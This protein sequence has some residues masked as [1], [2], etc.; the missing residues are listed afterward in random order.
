MTHDEN[1]GVGDR[2]RLG[3]WASAEPVDLSKPFQADTNTICLFH[4]DDV[5]GGEVKDVVPGGKSGKVQEPS[6]AEGK[7]AGALNCEADKGWADVTDLAKTE[8]IEALTVEC[9]VKFRGL[10]AGDVICRGDHT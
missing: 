4:L 2:G 1:G 7:F 5:A 6:T 3:R 9:W 8:G 10:A